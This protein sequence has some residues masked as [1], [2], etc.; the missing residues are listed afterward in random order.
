MVYRDFVSHPLLTISAT[1]F[2]MIAVRTPTEKNDLLP[3]AYDVDF[4]IQTYWHIDEQL[5]KDEQM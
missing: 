5:R 2:Q 3:P 4:S 1:S